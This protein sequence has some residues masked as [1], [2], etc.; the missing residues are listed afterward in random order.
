MSI[1]KARCAFPAL[2]I[3]VLLLQ[4]VASAD[5]DRY[6]GRHLFQSYCVICHGTDGKGGGP[7]MVRRK[8]QAA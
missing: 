1:F 4:T 2:M 5:P 8:S 3:W 6:I 7:L